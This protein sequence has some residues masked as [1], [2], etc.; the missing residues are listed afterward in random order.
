M[1]GGMD[2]LGI[3]PRASRMLSGCDATTP[4]ARESSAVKATHYGWGAR[5]AMLWLKAKVPESL[6]IP[7]AQTLTPDP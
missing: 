1:A 3:E 4:H 7:E 2:T 5:G 6:K